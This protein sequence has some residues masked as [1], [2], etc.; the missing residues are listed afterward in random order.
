MQL[1]YILYYNYVYIWLIYINTVDPWRTWV[2][3]VQTH[4]Y[5]NFFPINMYYIQYYTIYSWF[6]PWCEN[7]DMKEPREST[8]SY[9]CIFN[10][11]EG[12]QQ[13]THMLLKGQVH[14]H[15]NMNIWMNIW[16]YEYIVKDSI[17]LCYINQHKNMEK[18]L[19]YLGRKK[20]S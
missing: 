16:I 19:E 4:W 17:N 7:S 3:I 10:C 5:V 1:N 12:Q 8:I 15:Y 20:L 13:L 11:K 9:L 2:W 18:G 6:N 14:I